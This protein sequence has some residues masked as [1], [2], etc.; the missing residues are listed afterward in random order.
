MSPGAVIYFSQQDV[1][2]TLFTYKIC[3]L[4]LIEIKSMFPKCVIVEGKKGRIKKFP[5]Q[6]HTLAHWM[7]P[8]I[9]FVVLLE[10]VQKLQFLSSHDWL[11]VVVMKVLRLPL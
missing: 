4:Q 2:F 10:A 11:A 8:L 5:L 1:Y 9:H 6:W 3:L 7:N